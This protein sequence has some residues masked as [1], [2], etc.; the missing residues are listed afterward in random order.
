[1]QKIKEQNPLRETLKHQAI[2]ALVSLSITFLSVNFLLSYIVPALKEIEHNFIYKFILSVVLTYAFIRFYLR[3]CHYKH[4]QA[5]S[6]ITDGAFLTYYKKNSTTADIQE[7]EEML[8]K[9]AENAE[10]IRILGAS[11]LRTYGV[12]DAPLYENI[13]SC[14]ELFVLMLHPM[15]NGI[16]KRVKSLLAAKRPMFNES[17]IQRELSNYIDEIKKAIATLKQ[18]HNRDSEKV[19]LCFYDEEPL[20]KIIIIDHQLIWFQ[21]YE[22][23]KHVR[24]LPAYFLEKEESRAGTGLFKALL[25]IFDR[26]WQYIEKNPYS[27]EDNKIWNPQTKQYEIF[28]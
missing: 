14:S 16:K 26:K 18:I 19:K 20:L 28:Y 8:K 27:F 7:A 4:L 21:H 25:D 1:M 5:Q 12:S 9:K 22:T 6:V 10:S 24:D 23:G 13:K 11:G 3:F 15:G 2:S 17:D